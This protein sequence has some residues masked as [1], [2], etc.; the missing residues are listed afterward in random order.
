MPT[1]ALSKN[2]GILRADVGIGPYVGTYFNRV[3]N[4]LAYSDMLQ[5][6]GR[7][8][9]LFILDLQLVCNAPVDH[10]LGFLAAASALFAQVLLCEGDT[11]GGH[12]G[13]FLHSQ[14]AL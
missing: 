5:K 10:L 3:N 4:N 9:A 7:S 14:L 8:A 1:S 6:Q 13:L 11:T 2:V 12:A